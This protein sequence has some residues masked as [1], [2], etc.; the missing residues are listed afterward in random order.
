VRFYSTTQVL[1]LW[2]SALLV[3]FGVGVLH[4]HLTT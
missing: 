2:C 1:Q 4:A 3:G